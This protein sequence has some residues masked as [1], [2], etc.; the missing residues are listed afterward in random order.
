[1]VKRWN[2]IKRMHCTLMYINYYCILPLFFFFFFNLDWIT[3][4]YVLLFE[5]LD[6]FLWT[7][8]ISAGREF[9]GALLGDGKESSSNCS[10]SWGCYDRLLDYVFWQ[11]CHPSSLMCS[12]E[13]SDVIS[14]VAT[15][16]SAPDS[17]R[18]GHMFRK[19]VDKANSKRLLHKR[20][21]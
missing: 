19:A 14:F 9:F 5:A 12:T 8:C 4:W 20:S 10:G 15:N 1:M 21:P 3:R 16:V 18:T 11:V 17:K 2:S 6:C 13:C 7:S